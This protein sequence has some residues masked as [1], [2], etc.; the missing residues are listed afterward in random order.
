MRDKPDI[1]DLLE[2]ARTALMED[3]LPRLAPEHRYRAH[4]VAAAMATAARELAAGPAPEAGGA[5]GTCVAPRRGRASWRHSIA[6]FAAKLRA[7]AFDGSEAAYALLVRSTAARLA[8]CNPGYETGQ[9]VSPGGSGS[10]A[11]ASG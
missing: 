8:E 1:A 10:P 2:T 3:L 7:G 11:S 5:G 6:R 9:G 4:L